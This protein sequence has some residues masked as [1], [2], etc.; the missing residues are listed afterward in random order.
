MAELI[1]GSSAEQLI[2]EGIVPFTE[3][4][5]AGNHGG[6]TLVTFGDEVME[7]FSV[8]LTSSYKIKSRTCEANSSKMSYVLADLVGIPANPHKERKVFLDSGTESAFNDWLV[9]RVLKGSGLLVVI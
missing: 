9:C 2:G 1:Q 5:V 8:P 4:E 7:V 6:D 3:F